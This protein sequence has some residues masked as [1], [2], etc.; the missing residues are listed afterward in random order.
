[1]AVDG[2]IAC[3]NKELQEPL[4]LLEG[5]GEGGYGGSELVAGRVDELPYH[6]LDNV[7]LERNLVH[8]VIVHVCPVLLF[9]LVLHVGLRNNFEETK[10]RCDVVIEP[11]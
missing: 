3:R 10:I 5:V 4:A 1:M 8:A 11:E 2:P 9:E 6:L 7:D